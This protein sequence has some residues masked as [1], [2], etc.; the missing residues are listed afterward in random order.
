MNS[1]TKISSGYTNDI[2]SSPVTKDSTDDSFNGSSSVSSQSDISSTSDTSGLFS[3]IGKINYTKIGLTIVILLFLGI[4][5]LS[6]LGDFLQKIK[7]ISAP[8]LKNILE[9]LGYVITET[10]KDVT[11]T[12]ATGAKLGVDVAAGT[13]ESGLDVIQGQLDLDHSSKKTPSPKQQ[14]ASISASLKSALSDA[15]DKSVPL[16]D[17]ATSSTQRNGSNKSGYCYIGED[18]GFRSCIYVNE[19]DTCMSGDIFPSR[20]LCVNPSLRE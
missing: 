7:E 6:Y 14:Q 18:R 12:A 16:P 4:N 1:I 2:Y 11:S 3:F 19:N 13:I 15:E 9:S 5:V 17:D 10:T 8:F 20:E